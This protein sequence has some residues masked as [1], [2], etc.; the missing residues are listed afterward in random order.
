MQNM[1]KRIRVCNPVKNEKWFFFFFP[2]NKG[3]GG[4]QEAK[5]AQRILAYQGT[6]HLK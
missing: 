5:N 6:K 1:C 2:D 4:E 3:K